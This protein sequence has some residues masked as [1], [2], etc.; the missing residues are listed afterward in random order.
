MIDSKTFTRIIR[1]S[2]EDQLFIG[3]LPEIAPDCCDGHSVQEVADLLDEI[4]EMS[5]QNCLACNIPFDAPGSAMVIIPQAARNQDTARMVC[6]L[7]RDL[8]LSQSDFATALGVSKSTLS[9]WETGERRPDAAA[10]K[11]LRILK[12]QPSCITA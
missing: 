7:R 4:A 6:D 3:S 5:L 8:K 11:L 12:T 1:W 9:K 10:A 2:E